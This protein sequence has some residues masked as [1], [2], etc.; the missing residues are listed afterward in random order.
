MSS[1]PTYTDA[2]D[3]L[4]DEAGSDA[5]KAD[6][7]ET[8]RP[9]GE[10]AP[11]APL[12][13]GLSE[14]GDTLGQGGMGIVRLATQRRLQRSVA[15]KSLKDPTST[16]ARQH[17]LHEGLVAGVLEHPNILPVHDIVVDEQGHPHIV[18]KRVEGEPWSAW[19]ADPDR[20]R[21]A[22]G[23]R[24]PLAWNLRVLLSV[25]NA[26][27]YA[28]DRGI[29][30][31]DLKLDNVMIGRFG[32]VVVLD[33]GIAVALDERY[34][35]RLPLARDQRRMAGTPRMMA[36]E[37]CL[38]KG[39]LLGVRTDVYLLGGVLFQV[40]A[41]RSPHTGADLREVLAGIP[42]FEPDLP[43]RVPA[44]LRRIVARAMAADPADRF[45]DVASL[46][47]EIG[48]FLE[49]RGSMRL[50]ARANAALDGLVQ[51]LDRSDAPRSE[52]FRR[53]DEARFG[54]E[55]ALVDWP[56]NPLARDGLVEARIR[57]AT[58]EIAHGEPATA[59][60][61]LQLVDEVPAELEVAL[62]VALADREA[63]RAELEAR[64]V[65]AD[66]SVGLRTRMFV[67]GLVGL[68]WILGPLGFIPAE[69]MLRWWHLHAVSLALFGI[70]LGLAIWARD[71]LSKTALNRS[72]TAIVLFVP[73]AQ[74]AFDLAQMGLDMTP[75]QAVLLRPALWGVLVAAYALTTVRGLWPV[76]MVFGLVAATAGTLPFWLT[77]VAVAGCNA[78]LI[79]A[80]ARRWWMPGILRP[81]GE[82]HP[83][84][85][86]P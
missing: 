36:P 51:A 64:R 69:G 68:L 21:E 26:M 1:E 27:S 61:L 9:R 7:A 57:F 28:H 70:V 8:I 35:E 37:M 58:W 44:E 83:A 13:G 79:A 75:M 39:E 82:S 32:E 53:F 65:D 15:V 76:A 55:Q 25:C 54:F 19:A 62:K 45:T 67:F 72:S 77:Q 20:V 73:V 29:L 47:A 22:F 43:P 3:D 41:R 42:D 84:E 38:G 48:A 71:S 46:A 81:R 11:L 16:R 49:H 5:L 30:H 74:V 17:L 80:L 59:E 34:G 85:G 40:L 12:P 2:L 10:E 33:W 14:F 78:L 52:L 56:D 31:R 24:D 23:V 86:P 4:L 18:M 6:P 66:P 63:A 50:A 60:A